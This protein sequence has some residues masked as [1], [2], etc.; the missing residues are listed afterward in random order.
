MRRA[1]APLILLLFLV[2]GCEI[3]KDPVYEPLDPSLHLT[4]GFCLLANNR[5]VFNH[6]DID[7][8]DWSAH[9]IYLKSPDAFE[10]KYYKMGPAAVYA[11]SSKIYDLSFVSHAASYIPQGPVIWFP[12]IFYPDYTVHIGMAWIHPSLNED[13]NDPREDPRIVEALKK[14]DQFRHGLQCEILSFWYNEGDGVILELELRNEDA[15]NY[16][17]WDPDKIGMERYHYVTNG[18]FLQHESGP[19]Y[20]HHIQ[21]LSWE[22]ADPDR[23]S[24]LESDSSVILTI[25]Y[26]TFDEVPPGNYRAY[27]KFPGPSK[28][29]KREDLDLEDGRIW[30]GDLDLY[31]E[32]VIQ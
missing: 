19:S 29:E 16:Y 18:L 20:T 7:Y 12:H 4:D 11:D 13:G 32:V 31:A 28:V 2:A 10:E 1:I 6:Y 5:V 17:Y 26:E 15:V 22:G 30:L 21:H 8:Y 27:F 23:M 25:T 14:Y 3:E 9:L 24:L